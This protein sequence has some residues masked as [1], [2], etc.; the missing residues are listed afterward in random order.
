MWH[1]SKFANFITADGFNTLQHAVLKKTAKVR[2]FF[3]GRCSHR[4]VTNGIDCILIYIRQLWKHFV[5]HSEGFY[6]KNGCA[7][8][9]VEA[10][11]KLSGGEPGCNRGPLE[12][13]KKVLESSWMFF[14]ILETL[15]YL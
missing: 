11:R 9:P 5:W 10:G 12:Q 3:S 8:K 1:F 4:E 14:S 6:S 15:Q 2:V 7:G 13:E